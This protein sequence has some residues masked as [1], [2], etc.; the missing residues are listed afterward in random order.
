MT[1][2][3]ETGVDPGRVDEDTVVST[4]FSICSILMS[5]SFISSDK[6]DES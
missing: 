2:L 3:V 1:L 6:F 4:L 5:V